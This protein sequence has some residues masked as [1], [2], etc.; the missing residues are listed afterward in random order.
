MQ[1]VYSGVGGSS[2][3]VLAGPVVEQ[4]VLGSH[5]GP[6]PYKAAGPKAGARDRGPRQ[7]AELL[8]PPDS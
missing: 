6:R 1:V 7:L 2:K 8:D 4:W 3:S 5:E